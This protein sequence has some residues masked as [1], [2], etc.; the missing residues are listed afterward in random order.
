M[1]YLTLPF[2]QELEQAQTILLA[3]AGGGFDLFSG[4]PLYFGLRSMGK[5]V[6]LA[7]VSFAPLEFSTGRRLSPALVEVTATTQG[8][9]SY[10]PEKSLAKWFA[11]QGEPLPIYSF[12]RTGVQPLLAAYQTLIDLLRVDTIILVDGGTDS[13]LRG[14]ESG[15]GTPEEDVTSIVAVHQLPL[16]RKVLVCLCFGV[17]HTVCH[18]QVLEA[19]SQLMSDGGFLGAWS[20]TRDM[21][22]VQ[23]YR[24]ATEAVL[25]ETPAHWSIVS[26]S[27]LSALAGQFGN[28]HTIKQTAGSTLFI[29]AL[30]TLYWCFRVDAVAQRLLYLNDI[31]HT[32]TV[33]D[34][35]YAIGQFRN[36]LPT[37]KKWVRL[38]M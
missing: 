21:P 32:Y 38:P 22:E 9:E 23:R 13:L 1:P 29:N 15:L 2:F 26:S 36:T 6:H 17:D 4:L 16:E 28:V 34:V 37:K 20:L 31:L 7:S 5:Q 12:E 14:D 27:V 35:G 24:E 11:A 18:A 3:G 19:I 10:F 25:Q 33:E 30:M 8:R